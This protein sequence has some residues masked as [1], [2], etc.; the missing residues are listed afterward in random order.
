MGDER[1]A[2]WVLVGKPEGRRP[3][4]G[5]WHRWED[6]IKWIFRKWYAGACTGLIWTRMQAFV[7]LL[8]MQFFCDRN[9]F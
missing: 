5:P 3:F 6:Y 8:L 4:A 7:G 9:C 2:Y 1:S